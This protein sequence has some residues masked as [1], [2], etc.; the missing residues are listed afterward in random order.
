MAV[1]Q[2]TESFHG[3]VNR[4]VSRCSLMAFENAIQNL[5]DHLVKV[6]HLLWWVSRVKQAEEQDEYPVALLLPLLD[7]VRLVFHH[8]LADVRRQNRFSKGIVSRND[9]GPWLC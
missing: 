2:V 6:R 1:E 9:R 7:A 8:F 4:Q 5:G 3:V